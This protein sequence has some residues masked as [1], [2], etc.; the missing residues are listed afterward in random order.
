M[1]LNVE[2]SKEDQQEK[3]TV[4]TMEEEKVKASKGVQRKNTIH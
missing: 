1:V 3:I 2:C 4:L